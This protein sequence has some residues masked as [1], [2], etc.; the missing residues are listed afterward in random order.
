MKDFADEWGLDAGD[1]HWMTDAAVLYWPDGPETYFRAV[2]ARFALPGD[3]TDLYRIYRKRY[4]AGVRTLDG[5]LDGL[6]AL[7]DHGWRTAIITN[8]PVDAQLAKIR[9]VGLDRLVDAVCISE[10]ERTTPR[11]AP[12]GSVTTYAGTARSG[13]ACTGSGT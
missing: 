9:Q 3:P 2:A 8:G 6:S 7:R 12:P 4:L 10:A 1:L 13:T 5:C 11:P